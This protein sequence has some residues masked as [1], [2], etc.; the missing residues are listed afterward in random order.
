MRF[1][2]SF[3]RVTH[4]GSGF[5]PHLSPIFLPKFESWLVVVG[6]A[7]WSWCDCVDALAPAQ[8]VVGASGHA[9]TATL[10][11]TLVLCFAQPHDFT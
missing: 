6:I 8:C 7:R 4:W 3:G 1:G 5:F 9:G 2:S 10:F 11:L